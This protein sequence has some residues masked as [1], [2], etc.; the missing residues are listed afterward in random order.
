[1]VSNSLTEIANSSSISG[2]E[3][4]LTSFSCTMN[5]AVRTRAVLIRDAELD[6]L[7]LAGAEPDD[8]RL[9][10]LHQP[11]LAELDAVV[12]AGALGKRLAVDEALVVDDDEV[13]HRCGPIDRSELGDALAEPLDLL[14]DGLL[15]H[16]DGLAHAVEPLVLVDLRRRLHLHLGGEREG[17]ALTG[18]SVQS[19]VGRSMGSTPISATAREY[20]PVRWSRRAS[21]MSA[22]RPIWRAIGRRRLALAEPGNP[23]ALRQIGQSM[24]EG[25]IHVVAV[26]LDLEADVVIG[27]FGDLSLHNLSNGHARG[28]SFHTLVGSRAKRHR[29]HF[30]AELTPL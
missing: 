5:C 4:S 3:R 10:L 2:S 24:L 16:L 12:G 19:M 1:M 17:L 27:E 23:D 25:V 8:A 21:S 13:A 30:R 7:P 22:S 14:I 20:H 26:H 28:R 9:E 18:S 6:G 15:R 29:P 11:P